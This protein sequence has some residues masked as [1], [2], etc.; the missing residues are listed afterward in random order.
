MLSEKARLHGDRTFYSGQDGSF[1]YREIDQQSNRVAR[2][3]SGL[4]VKKGDKVCAFLRNR[5]EFIL[6]FFGVAKVGAVLV[7][8]NIQLQQQQVEHIVDNSD[9]RVL[10]LEGDAFEQF[11]VGKFPHIKSYVICGAASPAAGAIPFAQLLRSSAEALDIEVAFSDLAA[12]LYTSGTTGPPKGVMCSHE[13]YLAGGEMFA[14]LLSVTERDVCRAALPLYHVVGQLQGILTPLA[15][16][17]KVALFERFSVSRYWDEIKQNGITTDVLT[18]T[19]ANFL[20]Q[21]PAKPDDSASGIRTIMSFPVPVDA[22]GFQTRFDLTIINSYGLT[23]ALLPLGRTPGAPNK[24]GS[25]GRP[26]DYEVRV[27]DDADKELPDLEVGNILVRPRDVSRRIFDGYYKMP[28][29]SLEAL[30]H[31]WF[32]TGDLGYRDADGFFWFSGRKKDVIRF[33]GENVSATQVELVVLGHP[34]IAECAVIGVPAGAGQEED[35][36]LLARVKEGE[37]VQPAEL[38]RHCEDN[39][40]WFM[41]PRYV[42]LVAGLPRNATDKVEKYKLKEDWKNERT[43]DREAAGYKLKSRS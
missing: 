25:L 17:A 21:A 16:G 10:V 37:S 12:L 42:E 41:V 29:A 28:D 24:L 8:V 3:L 30:R 6:L 20:Y 40:A 4:G 39:I 32:H 36:K 5:I 19:Q 11:G 7:P 38:I 9:A 35:I 1:T 33:R 2:G 31:S 18:G 13:Y 26:T 15:V 22:E 34:K 14:Y 27:A 23:E 43:W